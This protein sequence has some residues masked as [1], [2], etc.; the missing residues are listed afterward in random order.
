MDAGDIDFFL[1]I[2]GYAVTR[3]GVAADL[4]KLAQTFNCPT[5]AAARTLDLAVFQVYQCRSRAVPTSSVGCQATAPTND[6]SSPDTQPQGTAPV[7][8]RRKRGPDR[9]KRRR[10]RCPRCL[11]CGLPDEEAQACPGN[12]ESDL[13]WY[14]C[15]SDDEPYR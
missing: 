1:F 3:H 4:K 9:R 13:C 8:V 11:E 5:I 14:K 7:R 10:R 6:V 12:R 2:L 15:D